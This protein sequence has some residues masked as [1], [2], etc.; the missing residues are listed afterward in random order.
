[1]Q[2]LKDL[3]S[4]VLKFSKQSLTQQQINFLINKYKVSKTLIIFLFNKVKKLDIEQLRKNSQIIVKKVVNTIKPLLEKYYLSF[5]KWEENQDK[6][7][8]N[9]VNNLA[10]KKLDNLDNFRYYKKKCY[11]NEELLIEVEYLIH[12]DSGFWNIEKSYKLVND[13]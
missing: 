13:F 8:A 9:W 12:Q 4:Y 2:I 10:L 5:C 6:T 7:Q 3:S 11:K 1:M